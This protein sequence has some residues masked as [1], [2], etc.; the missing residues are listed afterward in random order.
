MSPVTSSDSGGSSTGLALLVLGLL[1]VLRNKN[2]LYQD[3]WK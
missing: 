1:M 3:C 2:G